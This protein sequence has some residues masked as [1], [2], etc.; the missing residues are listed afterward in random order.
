[1]SFFDETLDGLLEAIAIEYKNTPSKEKGVTDCLIISADF[2]PTDEY[3]L[4]VM[5]R[6]H[7][8]TRVINL[9]TNDE[10]LDVYNKLIG[11]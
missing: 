5:R 7:T 9:L 3:Y 1:M 6:D 2:S 11:K 4:A 10:A 8:E